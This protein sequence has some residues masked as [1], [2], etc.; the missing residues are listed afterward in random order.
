MFLFGSGTAWA[1]PIIDGAGNTVTN[2]TPILVGGNA[3]QEFDVSDSTDTKTLYGNLKYPVA[4]AQGKGKLEI[5]CKF[6][7]L[8][9]AAMNSLLRGQSAGVAA[10]IDSIYFDT[11]AGTSIPTTPFQIT[12]T[13]PSSGTWKTDLGVT[14]TTT[15]GAMTRVASSPAAGQYSVA[16]GVYTFASA[17]NVSA[18]KV[19]ISYEYTA[20]S[21]TA[22]KCTV[23]N[24]AMGTAPFVQLYLLQYDNSG[25]NIWTRKYYNVLCSEFKRSSKQDDFS[26]ADVKFTAFSDVGGNLFDENFT[27]SV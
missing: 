4:V 8:N 5:S 22:Q 14:N 24:T 7:S 18:I 26:I 3:F 9:L 23:L 1:V 15:G 27:T 16:A 19:K 6:G 11:S 21:T 25:L 10:G 17:D 13:A 2:P 12:P 20:T